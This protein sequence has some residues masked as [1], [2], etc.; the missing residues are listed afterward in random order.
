MIRLIDKQVIPFDEAKAQLIQSQGA[1]V[2]TEWVRTQ[3]QDGGLQVNPKYGRFDTET[4]SVVPL[5][6]TDPSATD[7]PAATGP[8]G[9]TGTVPPTP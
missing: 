6:S 5:D 3:V 1:T 7:A 8:T 4:L 9:A 2:Y